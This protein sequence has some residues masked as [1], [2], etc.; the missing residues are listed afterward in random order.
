MKILSN[1]DRIKLDLQEFKVF[2]A[3]C[4]EGGAQWACLNAADEANAADEG[5]KRCGSSKN[6]AATDSRAAFRKL[7]H[8]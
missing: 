5:K 3:R 4:R 8:W 2:Y 6:T 1:R 7:N